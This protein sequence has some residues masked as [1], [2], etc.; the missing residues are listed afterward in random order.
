MWSRH[1][2]NRVAVGPRVCRQTNV[3]RRVRV[4]LVLLGFGI[5]GAVV[6]PLPAG[7]D[8]TSP[9]DAV[10]VDGFRPPASRFGPGNRGLEYGDSVG[11]DVSAVDAGRV[12]FAGR[13]GRA[14]HVVVDHGSGLWS[15]YA[16]LDS[17]GVVRGQ[18]VAK[19]QIVGVAA[20][21][22]HLTARLAGIYIDPALLL[23]GAEVIV[24]LDRVEA[25]LDRVTT[26]RSA[27]VRGARW[28]DRV[29]RTSSSRKLGS[30]LRSA[31][32]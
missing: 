12:I 27:S 3:L 6:D 22:F 14:R 19:G 15:T 18:R 5:I 20:S 31:R 29:G 16:F 28:A 30:P 9:I 21:G 17:V 4:A 32:W 7:A 1:L 10:V 25:S 26:P 11:L 8:W 13:V 2:W 24:Q 23:A